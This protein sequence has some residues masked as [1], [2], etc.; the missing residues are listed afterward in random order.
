MKILPLQSVI[1]SQALLPQDVV[2][3]DTR[4]GLADVTTEV[5]GACGGYRQQPRA[6][7]AQDVRRAVCQRARPEGASLSI[8]LFLEQFP[9]ISGEST[10]ALLQREHSVRQTLPLTLPLSPVAGTG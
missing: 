3:A 1:K 7:P 9:E 2:G 4:P 5:R 10:M 6:S 8:I